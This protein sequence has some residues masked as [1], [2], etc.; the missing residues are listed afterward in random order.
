MDTLNDI[1]VAGTADKILALGCPVC[2]GP[3]HV[4]FTGGKKSSVSF[5]CEKCYYNLNIDGD[6]PAPPWVDVLGAK[7]KTNGTSA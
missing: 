4:N 3:M 1:G 5:F 2:A 7:T 6:F